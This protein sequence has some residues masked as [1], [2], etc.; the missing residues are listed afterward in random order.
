[1][2]YSCYIL[3]RFIEE[4]LTIGVIGLFPHKI[5]TSNIFVQTSIIK[6]FI[7]E[8]QFNFRSAAVN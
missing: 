8:E 1:M 4:I 3:I 6:H 2:T 5:L 7:D